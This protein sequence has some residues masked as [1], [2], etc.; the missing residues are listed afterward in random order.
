MPPPETKTKNFQINS[1]TMYPPLPPLGLKFP[2]ASRPH[3]AASH[4]DI[5]V[6][7]FPMVWHKLFLITQSLPSYCIY[8]IKQA[9]KQATVH[10]A[11]AA[12]WVQKKLQ[13]WL[14]TEWPVA[15]LQRIHVVP[16]SALIL[17]WTDNQT[18]VVSQ[19]NLHSHTSVK[20]LNLIYEQKFELSV[21]RDIRM[22]PVINVYM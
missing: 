6:H 22:I 9:S 21:K 19:P 14:I 15:L 4:Q 10:V 5:L 18:C 13:K 1:Q 11:M 17:P 7:A 2:N 12:L 16:F 3:T 8:C 20:K